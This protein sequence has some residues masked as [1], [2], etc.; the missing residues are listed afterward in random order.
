M[1]CNSGFEHPEGENW[2]ITAEAQKPSVAPMN[3]PVQPKLLILAFKTLQDLVT[4]FIL[5]P[6][7]PFHIPIKLNF[8]LLLIYPLMLF[9]C[10]FG[11][12]CLEPSDLHQRTYKPYL[13]LKAKVKFLFF[14]KHL[15][16]K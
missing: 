5:S 13:A 6:M 8:P 7:T 10:S 4:P 15:L 2:S 1:Q 3:Y 11:F 14:H 9:L 16:Q 12:L